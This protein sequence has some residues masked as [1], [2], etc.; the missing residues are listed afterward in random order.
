MSATGI[1]VSFAKIETKFGYDV[2]KFCVVKKKFC[3]TTKNLYDFV[4]FGNFV[5]YDKKNCMILWRLEILCRMTNI[6]WKSN[7]V[8]P[9]NRSHQPPMSGQH[10]EFQP[11]MVKYD[12]EIQECMSHSREVINRG[13]GVG[14]KLEW[15]NHRRN[16]FH[17]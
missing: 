3:M 1:L 14:Y 12:L 4:T 7:T 16:L 8:W 15:P 17:F 13:G 2:W 9:N 5:S 11:R 10:S 6:F